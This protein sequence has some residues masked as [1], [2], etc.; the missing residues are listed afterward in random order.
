M[1]NVPRTSPLPHG[2]R[3]V[4]YTVCLC[5][6]EVFLVSNDVLQMNSLMVPCSHGHTMK[7]LAMTLRF[8]I[9]LSQV[10]RSFIL[11]SHRAPIAVVCFILTHPL[12]VFLKEV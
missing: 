8:L 9:W 10:P 12:D 1:I 11:Q 4:L 5:L 7:V 3:L 6:L 2:M